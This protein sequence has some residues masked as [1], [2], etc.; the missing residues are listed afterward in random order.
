MKKPTARRQSNN[1]RP[2]SRSV[3]TREPSSSRAV[4]TGKGGPP[5]RLAKKMQASAGKGLS[6]SPED[7]LVPLAVILQS[8]SPQCLK[9]NP[10]Y[11][12]GAE[13]GM[14]WLKNAP[15][16]LVDGEEG[17][18][19]QPCYYD[20]LH[21]VEWVPREAGGGFVARHES[22]PNDAKQ[23]PD[24][25]DPEGKKMIWKRP[26]G[27]DLVQT[28]SYSGIIYRQGHAFPYAIPLSSTN[29]QFGRALMT[30]L[31]QQQ[32]E[33]GERAP[34]FSSL[35]H[36]VT[37]FR[38]NT[39]GDWFAFELAGIEWLP[40][41]PEGEQMYAAGEALFNAFDSGQKQAARPETEHEEGSGGD[42]ERM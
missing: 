36:V 26:N 35:A 19:F 10:A 33:D 32:L 25:K 5:G 31:N 16:P 41:S 12:D 34:I 30:Q 27:N 9:R 15:D 20:H 4:T 13:A 40:D 1:R 22:L 14:I 3:A 2:Q 6:T 11:I 29:H 39:R 21:W 7:N 38:Q 23:V 8:N 42:N 24:P 37:R 28:R 18:L 17:F